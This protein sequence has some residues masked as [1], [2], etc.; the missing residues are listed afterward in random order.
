MQCTQ[1]G[2]ISSIKGHLSLY[3]HWGLYSSFISQFGMPVHKSDAYLL[4]LHP[5]SLLCLPIAVV[6]FKLLYSVC[7]S[8]GGCCLS[9]RSSLDRLVTV[10]CSWRRRL[11]IWHHSTTSVV[12]LLDTSFT[13]FAAGAASVLP[14]STNWMWKAYRPWWHVSQHTELGKF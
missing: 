11:F 1:E 12:C 2:I 9:E 3:C 4:R 6:H 14:Q 5:S 10:S 8:F 13:L 7:V